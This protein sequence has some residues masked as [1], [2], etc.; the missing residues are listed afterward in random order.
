MRL[1]AVRAGGG[2]PVATEVGV[3]DLAERVAAGC[4]VYGGSS[5][6]PRVVIPEADVKP[7]GI[8]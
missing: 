1:Q 7:P 2:I 3:W 5:A 6:P 4:G 8:L